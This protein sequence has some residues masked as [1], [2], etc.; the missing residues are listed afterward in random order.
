MAAAARRVDPPLLRALRHLNPRAP[1]DAGLEGALWCHADVE[2]GFS[3]TVRRE[4]QEAHLRHLDACLPYLH[5]RLEALRRRH[6]AHLRAALNHEEA[7]VWAVDPELVDA[8]RDF[9]CKLAA[10]LVQPGSTHAA[11]DWWGVAR[12]ILDRADAGMLERHADVLHPL[13]AARVKAEGAEARIP[14]WADPAALAGLLDDRRAPVLAWLVGDARSGRLV[15]QAETPGPRQ[16]PLGLPLLID[17]GGARVTVG[18][19]AGARTRWV[20]AAVLPASLCRLSKPDPVRITTAREVLTV[21][22]VKRPRGALEWRCDRQGIAIRCP[23]LGPHTW[24]FANAFLHAEPLSGPA[25]PDW[26]L[27]SE[28]ATPITL[29]A[30]HSPGA[31][32]QFGIDAPF[33]VYADLTVITPNGSATQRLRWI[34]PGSFL[35]G[36]P[37][38]EPER[39]SDEGPRHSVTLTHG[40]WLADT[41]CTQALWRVVMGTNPSRFSGDEQRPVERV[42]WHNVQE[43]LRKLHA[44]LSD[45]EAR[46]PTEA[47]WEYACRAGSDTPFSF[48]ANITSETVNYDGNYPYAGGEKDL[49]RN[50]T[51]PVKS[52]PPN[53]WGLYEMHGNVL[54]WCMDGMRDYSDEEQVD[55]VGPVGEE[56]DRAVRGGSWFGLAWGA[57]S[58]YRIGGPPGLAYDALGFRLCLRSV[59]PG[60]DRPGGPAVFAAR[61]ARCFEPAEG[62]GGLDAQTRRVPGTGRPRSTGGAGPVSD[63]RIAARPVDPTSSIARP[64]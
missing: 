39:G 25:S 62:R 42:S 2:A 60:R 41:A 34:E 52:L 1:L 22:A 54:E 20:S 4:A 45:C 35:M 38:D 51:V 27:T 63:C 28:F 33:G 64:R 18:E 12:G 29:G 59:E 30:H 40:F 36:S 53:S 44:L 6:H 7:L 49:Y 11:G 32:V 43:F 46:L 57:R 21:A 23:A 16:S 15:L 37:E 8:A 26:A 9:M 47:E 13:V 17:A 19:G 56:A 58:A 10:T 48:G 14:G 31:G 5:S 50:Q 3:A 55:P 61:R 24:Q